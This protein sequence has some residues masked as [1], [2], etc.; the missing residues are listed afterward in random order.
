MAPL[1]AIDQQAAGMISAQRLALREQLA[2]PAL[3]AMHAWLLTT[4]RSVT[5]GS[6]TAKAI[7]HAL[8][9]WL[10]LQ[11]TPAQCLN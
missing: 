3:A 6:G 8:K 1:Y 2:I 5:A 7:E 11:R 10:A 9:R 4:Q